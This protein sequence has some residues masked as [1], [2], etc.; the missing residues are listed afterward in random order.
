MLRGFRRLVGDQASQASLDIEEGSCSNLDIFTCAGWNYRDLLPSPCVC[1]A[2][3]SVL[4]EHSGS[5]LGFVFV[6]ASPPCLIL[7]AN[8][9]P[10][11]PKKIQFA[12]PLFQ[13]QIAPEAAEQVRGSG[14]GP[15]PGWWAGRASILTRRKGLCFLHLPDFVTFR[16][17]KWVCSCTCVWVV[18]GNV[19]LRF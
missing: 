13:S 4:Q 8:M 18:L 3:W 14:T 11:S 2:R 10:N 17:R 1:V 7:I 16:E 12:V 9:E 19:W 6:S 15:V 5:H